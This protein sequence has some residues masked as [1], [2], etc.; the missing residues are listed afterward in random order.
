MS[1]AQQESY[2]SDPSSAHGRLYQYDKPAQPG[3]EGCN[4]QDQWTQAKAV[5][6][7]FVLINAWNEWIANPPK[8]TDQFNREYSKD[9]EPMQGGHGDSYYQQMKREIATFK[10][11][12]PHF[13]LR[14]LQD[15]QV[16]FQIRPRWR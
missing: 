15:G 10:M 4:F 8:F 2:M 1:P 3:K 12:S 16:V 7:T 14:K 13:V 5:N 6:P 9:V 11:L